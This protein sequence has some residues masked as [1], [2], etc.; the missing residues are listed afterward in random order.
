MMPRFILASMM[1][2]SRW[3]GLSFITA[4]EGGKEAK[5]IAAKVSIMR[6]TQS[7][8]VTVSGESV[9]IKAPANTVQQAARF[10]VIWKRM[11]RC[12]F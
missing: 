4:S 3:R 7:I 6:F 2:A 11:N 5:A 1:K 8:C 10:T 12:M 9:P